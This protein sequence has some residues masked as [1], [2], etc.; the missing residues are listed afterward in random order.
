MATSHQPANHVQLPSHHHPIGP[1]T[2]KCCWSDIEPSPSVWCCGF[3]FLNFGVTIWDAPR[4]YTNSLAKPEAWKYWTFASCCF[5]CS[6]F[7]DNRFLL[8]RWS[9]NIEGDGG[10]RKALA[11]EFSAQPSKHH[12][13]FQCI[14]I[15]KCIHI[16]VFI[17]WNCV[18]MCIY[19]YRCK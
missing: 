12:D 4:I 11:A 1:A 16:R 15:R 14:H 9:V 17:V 3:F 10:C 8:V 19:I 5:W 6:P 2:A 18:Y 13:I 7:S